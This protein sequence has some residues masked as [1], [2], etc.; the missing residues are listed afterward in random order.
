MA[1][2]SMAAIIAPEEERDGGSNHF[3]DT[4]YRRD[5]DINSRR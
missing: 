4:A 5:S 1:T 3:S 2:C